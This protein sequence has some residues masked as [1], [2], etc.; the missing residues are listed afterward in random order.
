[1]QWFNV[2]TIVNTHGIRGEVRV[3]SRTHFPEE[4][5]YGRKQACLVHAGQQNAYLLN[6]GK[7]S[8]A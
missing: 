3:I 5:L 1:M 4:T 6:C 2:G 7:S 8:S